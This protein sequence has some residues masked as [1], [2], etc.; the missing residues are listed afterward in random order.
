MAKGQIRSTK[1]QRKPKSTDKKDAKHPRPHEL[2]QSTKLGA[3]RP[4]Q[5]S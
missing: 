1:E 2:I 4:G 3:P 5:K